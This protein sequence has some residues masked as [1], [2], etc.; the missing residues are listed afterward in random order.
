ME[1]CW[2]RRAKASCRMSCVSTCFKLQPG[3]PGLVRTTLQEW[4]LNSDVVKPDDQEEDKEGAQEETRTLTSNYTA[5]LMS[6]GFRRSFQ[7]SLPPKK[8][9]K[10][11][12]MLKLKKHEKADERGFHAGFVNGFRVSQSV[13]FAGCGCRNLP[14]I[15]EL[16]RNFLTWPLAE[17]SFWSSLCCSASWHTG[18]KH[19][20]HLRRIYEHF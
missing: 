3:Q 10:G 20:K 19:Y 2:S 8:G 18:T 16:E 17:L 13:H 9:K 1:H 12:N 14:L 11:S 6:V 7:N 15:Q 5:C 4:D